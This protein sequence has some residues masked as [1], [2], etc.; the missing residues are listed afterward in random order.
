M[1]TMHSKCLSVKK[2]KGLVAESFGKG[3][4]EQTALV[5]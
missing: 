5:N 3:L 1:E 2:A 4:I